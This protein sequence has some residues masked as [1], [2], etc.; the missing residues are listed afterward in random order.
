MARTFLREISARAWERAVAASPFRAFTTAGLAS[1]PPPK[2]LINGILLVESFAVLFGPPGVGKTFLALDW[3]LSIVF[4]RAWLGRAVLYGPVVY[5]AAEGDAAALGLRERAWKQAHGIS[6]VATPGLVFIAEPVNLLQPDA[7]Q[8]LID[9]IKALPARP[10]F[11]V[12]DTLAQSMVGGNEDSSQDMGRAADAIRRVMQTFGCGA[13]VLHHPTKSNTTNERGSGALRGAADAMMILKEKDDLI[14]LV[15]DKQKNAAK[16]KITSLRLKVHV[17]TDEEGEPLADEDGEP[18]TSCVVIRGAQAPKPLTEEFKIEH[19]FKVLDILVRDGEAT[20]GTLENKGGPNEIPHSTLTKA[21][22][23]LTEE[24]YV[25][26]PGH[27]KG[28]KYAPTPKGRK[29]LKAR[30]PA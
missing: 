21:L 2:W 20:F 18:I 25:T 24:G 11:V 16:F 3:V 8:K 22:T 4:G 13:L 15:S 28:A 10:I 6:E 17:L 9:F 19:R 27:G 5:V 1:L 23:F 12:F 30:R 7:V 14:K 26:N 29:V